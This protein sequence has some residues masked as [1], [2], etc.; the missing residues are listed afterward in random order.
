MLEHQR[1]YG[2]PMSLREL[3]LE[4]S[5]VPKG[6]TISAVFSKPPSAGNVRQALLAMVKK[7]AVKIAPGRIRSARYW[8]VGVVGEDGYARVAD[9]DLGATL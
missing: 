4:M 9:F 2:T 1:K 8:A 3:A 7:G 5:I 6:K